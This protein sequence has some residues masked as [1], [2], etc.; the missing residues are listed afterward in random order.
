LYFRDEFRKASAKLWE[1]EP[2]SD[3]AQRRE[4]RASLVNVALM[5]ARTLKQQRVKMRSLEQSALA[6]NSDLAPVFSH[7]TETLTD[8]ISTL[9]SLVP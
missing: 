6:D 8:I 5:A 2:M 1:S 4:N 9:E 7:A 3:A